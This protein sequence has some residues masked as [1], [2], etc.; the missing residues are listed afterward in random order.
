MVDRQKIIK[1]RNKFRRIK[2]YEY[3]IDKLLSDYFMMEYFSVVLN[4]KALILGPLLISAVLIKCT[5]ELEH[6]LN[7]L[8]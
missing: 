7:E 6:K 8:T 2:F 1:L 4:D 3:G 5:Y